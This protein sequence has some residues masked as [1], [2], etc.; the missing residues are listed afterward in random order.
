MSRAACWRRIGGF[1]LIEL[2]VATGLMVILVTAIAILFHHTTDVV[3]VNEAR[4]HVF[5]NARAAIDWLQKDLAGCLPV[6]GGQ[7]AFGLAQNFVPDNGGPAGTTNGETM[8]HG[9][10]GA[11]DAVLF[12]A[13]TMMA[14]SVQ[15]V[16]ILY[17]LR[18]D[19]DWSTSSGGTAGLSST[20]RTDRPL[21]SLMRY[22][23]PLTAVIT[24][25]SVPSPS[26]PPHPPCSRTVSH[27]V[28]STPCPNHLPRPCACD[29]LCEYVLS[30]NIEVYS[31]SGSFAA[32]G[33]AETARYWQLNQSGHPFRASANISS[34][35]YLI[36]DAHTPQPGEGLPRALRITMRVCDGAAERTERL[37]SRVVWIPMS[38]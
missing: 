22:V 6:S 12:N 17:C 15:P 30:F 29:A 24:G 25:N 32:P 10:P 36:G 20:V 14:G 2:L 35:P 34:P 7:Q 18:R 4:I 37:V 33:G 21:Y 8:T 27:G 9:N 31:R 28:A 1:T 11:T 19:S 3:K 26:D 5:S 23:Y 13:T 38:P 16:R